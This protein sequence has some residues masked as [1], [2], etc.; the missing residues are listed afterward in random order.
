MVS[1]NATPG[2][3]PSEAERLG[4]IT[5]ATELGWEP[6]STRSGFAMVVCGSLAALTR[7]DL[8]RGEIQPIAFHEAGTQKKLEMV[9]R[10][11]FTVAP[12]DGHYEPL[13]GMRNRREERGRRSV[14][15][16]TS[17]ILTW[18][19]FPWPV[20]MDRR[21]Q[22]WLAPVSRGQHIVVVGKVIK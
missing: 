1:Q 3:L 11:C 8:L 13:L 19:P 6:L 2:L 20:S 18:P 7:N 22:A 12:F 14:C 15:C 21:A 17:T 10:A 16:M 9:D 5:V 4:K